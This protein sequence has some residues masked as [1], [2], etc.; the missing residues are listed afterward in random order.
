M[1]LYPS[2]TQLI[3]SRVKKTREQLSP[4]K[5][6][7]TQPIAQQTAAAPPP[8]QSP[9]QPTTPAESLALYCPH[10]PYPKQRALLD[11]VELEALFG[12]AVGGGKSDVLLMAALQYVHL[13]GYAALI[14]RRDT[15]RL[16]LAG[17]LIPRSHEWL[18]GKPAQWNAALRRWSFPQASGPPASLTFGYLATTQ[19]KYR[20]ASSEF[21]YLGF[22]EL[23]ELREED[24]LFLFSRLRRIKTLDVPLRVRAAT[25]PGN[26]GHLWV[27]RRF[28]AGAELVQIIGDT[29]TAHNV[30]LGSRCSRR[31]R[32]ARRASTN[33]TDACLFRR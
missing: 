15:Q 18:A 17:G 26:V 4:A 20:Y 27:K 25:N 16:T 14:V 3:N 28:V 13:P 21:Q 6:S 23:T 32:C 9:S 24:Y 1:S 11:V 30:A 8:T 5:H 22:D 2:I 19:D 29:G 7:P 12:G 31:T 33:W 10:V